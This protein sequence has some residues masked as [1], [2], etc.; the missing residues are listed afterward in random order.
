MDRSLSRPRRRFLKQC[1]VGGLSASPLSSL[2]AEPEAGSGAEFFV[3]PTGKPDGDGSEAKPW[4]L[5]TALAHPKAVTP[6]SVIWLRE[7]TYRGGF[8]SQLAGRSD[9][10]ITLRQYPGERATVDLL[11]S[12]DGQQGFTVKGAWSRFQDFE[13]TCSDPRRRTMITGSFPADIQRGSVDC[14]A[15]HVKFINMVVHDLANGFGFWSE[16]EGGEI[17]GCIIYN[18][19][20]L[21]P[22]RGHGHAIYAQNRTGTKRLV[23]NVMFHQCSHGIHA[24]G[25]SQAFIQGFH[26][27]GNASFN[28]GAPAGPDGWSPN[29]LVGGGSAAQRVTLVGNHAY[30]SVG[31]TCVRLG[32]GA[33]NEDV[34][35][36]DN[37]FTGH[38]LVQ[39]WKRATV[40]GNR[41]TGRNTLV[42]LEL[43]EGVEPAAYNWDPNTYLS[44]EQRWTPLALARN[45]EALAQGWQAW[46]ARGLDK[47]SK[48]T[49][50][51]PRGVEVFVRPNQYEKGRAHVIVYNWDRQPKVTVDLARVLE[52]G[53]KYQVV[54][55]QDYFG[56][57]VAEGEY[58]GRPIDLPTQAR[59][60]VPP[61][62]LP[63]LQAPATAPEFNVFV[64][65]PIPA[66]GARRIPRGR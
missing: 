21:A 54:P 48:Y 49:E 51:Q 5:A 61:V 40:T 14:R 43:P 34:T 11:P 4:D 29:I 56:R 55:A 65:K 58:S 44:Q 30:H 18:N 2:S 15:S 64:V 42:R 9:A 28:N 36:R 12:K 16:G 32:Y 47:N 50:A 35:C 3:S 59:A 13:V 31:G 1:V 46:Q 62:G 26:L 41:F 27:E 7:G 53:M 8:V 63:E 33:L 39:S 20:W 17:Y 6:G 37:H 60:A 52:R 66:P 19:G 45:R 38:T 24:Y 22:D 23:D 57:P 25:S 10:P